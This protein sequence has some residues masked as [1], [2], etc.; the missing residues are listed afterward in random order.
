MCTARGFFIFR[1]NPDSMKTP[2]VFVCSFLL[3]FLTQYA[4]A[5]KRYIANSERFNAGL[6]IGINYSQ[7]DGD[8]FTGYD[9]KGLTG[10]IKGIVRIIPR[11]DFNMELLYSKKGSKIFAGNYTGTTPIKDQIIDLTYVDVPLLLKWK[12]NETENSWHIEAGVVYARLVDSEIVEAIRD[13]KR[14]F[15]YK[16]ILADFDSNELSWIGGLGYTF[17]SG[18]SFHGRFAFG[19]SKFYQNSAFEFNNPSSLLVQDIEFLR[20]YSMSFQVAY[21]IF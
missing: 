18:L 6:V 15:S 11:L 9:K 17:K 1:T 2:M 8:Y 16:T 5:Q 7:I 10:G 4:I 13:S 19:L 20:N 21:A 14:Q 12:L 3:L